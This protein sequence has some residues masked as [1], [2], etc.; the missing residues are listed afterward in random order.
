MPGLKEK[1]RGRT[2]GEGGVNPAPK[3]PKK[4]APK[5]IMGDPKSAPPFVKEQTIEIDPD[6]GP[7]GGTKGATI[8]SRQGKQKKVRYPSLYGT[9]GSRRTT[10]GR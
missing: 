9:S 3:A 5:I 1:A 6:V 7:R 8:G 4:K 10:S 2:I